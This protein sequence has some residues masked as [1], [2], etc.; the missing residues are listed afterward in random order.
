M[1]NYYEYTHIHILFSPNNAQMYLK[2]FLFF[3]IS[4]GLIS[5]FNL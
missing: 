3:K 2:Q 5:K 1:A 4:Y